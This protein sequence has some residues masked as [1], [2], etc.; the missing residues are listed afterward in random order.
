M[1]YKKLNS[2]D[3]SPSKSFNKSPVSSP[4][5]SKSK[6]SLL[7]KKPSSKAE[8]SASIKAQLEERRNSLKS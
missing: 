6:S 2:E 7:K 5:P 1:S 8:T 4:S 3:T